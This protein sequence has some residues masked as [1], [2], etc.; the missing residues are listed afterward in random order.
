MLTLILIRM[1][2]FD[3]KKVKIDLL[4]SHLNVKFAMEL[5]FVI[6]SIL[7]N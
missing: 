3:D 5:N 6:S 1:T 7:I 2:E 4:I